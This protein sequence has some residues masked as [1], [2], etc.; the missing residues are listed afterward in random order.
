MKF[1][2]IILL[3]YL[4]IVIVPKY[5]LAEHPV[6]SPSQEAAKIE[7]EQKSGKTEYFEY[8]LNIP[9]FSYLKH[10]LFEKKLNQ[11]YK[12]SI[13]SFQKNL[14][15]EAKKYY[16][17]AKQSI[18]SIH[19]YVVNIDYKVTY[20]KSPLL[21]L[22]ANYYQYTGG[23]HGMYEWRAET[24]DTELEK[25]LS[26]ADLFKKNSSYAPKIRQEIARQIEQNKDIYFPDAVEQIQNAKSLKYFLEP[27]HLIIYFPLYEIAPYSSG[28]PQFRIPYTLL[29]SDLKEKYREFLIDK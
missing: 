25:E 19:P 2:Y 4:F 26:L 6:A 21:S 23:A 22:Y 18:L 3:A 11:Y 1:R 8:Q 28:I 17:D 16:N 20:N 14:E 9:K 13:L 7:T 12:N 29:Q 5:A 15:K 24:F 10:E 27:E